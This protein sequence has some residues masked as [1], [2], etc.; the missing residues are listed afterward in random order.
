MADS[1]AKFRDNIFSYSVYSEG[2]KVDD[3][4][5]LTSIY[6]DLGVNRIGKATLKFN[7]GDAEA[8]TFGE[9][10]SDVFKPGTGIRLEV[11]EINQEKAIF[12]GIVIQLKIEVEEGSRTQMVVECRERVF[13]ATLGR[14]N[15][16]FE[17]KTDSEVLKEILGG[18][19]DVSVDS[20][21]YQHPALVQ[22]YCTDWDF[23]LSRAEAN[24]LFVSTAGSKISVKK[25]AIDGAPVL[26]VTYGNDLIDFDGGITAVS[27]FGDVEGV[28]WSPAQQ[29]MVSVKAAEPALNA[30][31]DLTT[32]KL[33]VSELQLCQTDAPLDAEALQ[34]LIDGIA[35]KNGLARYEGSFMFYGC[36]DVVPGCIIELA[37]M[38]KRFN[39][40][41]YVG[42]VEHVVEHNIWTTRAYMGI[43]PASITEEPDVVA[44][45]ASGWLPGIEGLH[46]GKVKKLDEDPLKEFRIRVELPWLN[47][48]KKEV[49]ARLA[50]LYAGK[51]YGSFF[52]PEPG[53]EVVVGFFNNDPCF[54]VV[55]G[56]LYSSKLAPGYPLEA[57]N[58]KKALVTRENLVVE[59]DEEKK[60]ISVRT[61]GNNQLEINDDGQC[62]TLSDQHKNKLLLDKDGITLEAAKDITLKAKGNIVL[63]ATSK[64]SVKAKSDV[65][66]EGMNVKATAKVG[67]TAKG[68]ATAEISA[69]GQTTVKGAMVMIN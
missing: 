44:P 23:A 40:K 48:E 17:D 7:A 49:W 34:A 12:E 25:P 46:V 43:L 30:Q 28:S 3:S 35:L 63:D 66:L 59:F 68:N 8:Q 51:Q 53:D 47:G 6:V 10:D 31:G 61:P 15:R 45:P 24:G 36:A 14:K 9:T 32:E 69:S 20:T 54:P 41:V 33:K 29:K 38:G 55:L 50:T 4:Y 26:T 11:G 42:Q 64:A 65:E 57:A 21:S 5:S 37:G 27:Q 22:Y 52:F 1:P 13:A 19:G 60:I 39:G 16:I 18:Y 56:S 67:F 58:H 2:T 62:I